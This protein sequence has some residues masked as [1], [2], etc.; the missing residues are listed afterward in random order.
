MRLSGKVVLITGGSGGIGSAT[1]LECAKEGAEAVYV[2]YFGSPERAA[3]VVQ[4]INASGGAGFSLRADVSQKS[5]ALA[6]ARQIA[7]KH[8]RI[9]AVTCYA[10]YPLDKDNW[11]G[12]FLSLTE[13][14]VKKPLEVDV[15]GSFFTAQA[16]LP[17]MLEKKRGSVVLVSSTPGLVGDT[18]GITYALGK[19]AIA[20]LAK[21]LAQLYG[22]RGIRANAI[23]PGSIGTPAN[24]AGLSAKDREVLGEES[25][26]RRFGTPEEVARLAV[27]L[28]SDDSSFMTGQTLVCDGGTVFS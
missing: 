1:A 24:L 16:V 19:A 14:Q 5:D 2:S 22:P 17:F 20:I 9:D 11:F 21:C 28:M 8:G 15:G 4:K 12:D 3:A 25:S 18:V 26:L 7:E 6:A 13:E 27:F 10:G 23:A